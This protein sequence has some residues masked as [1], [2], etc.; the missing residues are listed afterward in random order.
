ME[1]TNT[2]KAI[3]II[4]SILFAFLIWFYVSNSDSVTLDVEDVPVEFLNEERS[5][6][7]K[8]MMLVSG[9]DATVDLSLSMPRSMVYSFNPERVRIIADLSSIN[10]TGTQLIPYTI[11][12]PSNVNSSRVS[13]K[14]PSL[15]T[16][17][18][19]VGELFRRNI[20]IRCKLVGNVAPGYIA[21]S[22]QTLPE[23]LEIRGQQADIMP[24]SY[25]QVTLN[26]EDARS[27]IIEFLNFELYDVNDQ[28]VTNSHIHPASENI[29]VTMP[30]IAAKDVP[31]R[32]DFVESDGVRISSFDYTLDH[33]SVSISGDESVLAGMEEIVLDTIDLAQLGDEELT[34]TYDIALPEGIRNLSGIT[35]ATLTIRAR[36]LAEQTLEAVHFDYEN[37]SGEEEVQI[38]TSSMPVT[39][40]GAQSTLEALNSG[41]IHLIADLSEISD[42]TGNY[43]VPARVSI[44]GDPDVGVI[45]EY[46]VTIHVGT[47]E[48]EPEP[49]E[50][51]E[52]Q[53]GRQPEE[54]DG[55]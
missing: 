48:P 8:G 27:T 25:A 54:G 46:E 6:A 34:R 29:Q 15:R 42:A 51:A 33:E 22:I 28:L 23:E 40:R 38:L 43:T 36:D 47:P 17:E 35:T 37:Y 49:D 1:L 20:E 50:T 18:V 21:G 44:S 45:G 24:V 14:S 7:N 41:Q 19:Q 5:L 11:V 4:G 39:L 26:I 55:T 52:E 10:S 13:V 2:R 53:T 32:V 31:L 3:Y 16:V 12:Y 9:D 30:V